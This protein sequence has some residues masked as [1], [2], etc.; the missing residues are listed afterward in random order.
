MELLY[1]LSSMKNAGWFG[2]AQRERS[3][4]LQENKRLL[5]K[6]SPKPWHVQHVVWTAELVQNSLYWWKLN[7]FG[8]DGKHYVQHQT[9]KKAETNVSK[10][11]VKGGGGYV[12]IWGWF[13]GRS[14][15]SYTATWQREYKCLS[16]PP[17][18]KCI[19]FAV[20]V[21]QSAHNF[22]EPRHTAKQL[23]SSLKLSEL[24]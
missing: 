18:S 23:S 13:W 8:S 5:Q 16:E 11:W 10:K 9:R 21:S 19:S 4:L 2:D 15:V 20:S 17:L 14:W 7:L 12:R 6:A 1:M 22:H 3:G 24:K